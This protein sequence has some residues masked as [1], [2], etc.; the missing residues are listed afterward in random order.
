MEAGFIEQA[1]TEHAARAVV[2]AA[3]IEQA[4]TAG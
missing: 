1:A 3:L 4:L 2:D